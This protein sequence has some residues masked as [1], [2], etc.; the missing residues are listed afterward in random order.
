MYV[1]Q[2]MWKGTFKTPEFVTVLLVI[3][4]CADLYESVITW[5]SRTVCLETVTER[6]HHNCVFMSQMSFF[7]F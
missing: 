7:P 6:M 1:V 5:H 3:M 2:K 4:N